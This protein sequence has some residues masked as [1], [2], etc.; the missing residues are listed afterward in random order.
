MWSRGSAAALGAGRGRRSRGEVVAAVGAGVGGTAAVKE[1]EDQRKRKSDG[2]RDPERNIYFGCAAA[3]CRPP[4]E[5]ALPLG[6]LATPT[7]LADPPQ[8]HLPGPR[9]RCRRYSP[10]CFDEDVERTSPSLHICSALG[11][12]PV[13]DNADPSAREPDGRE[14]DGDRRCSPLPPPAPASRPRHGGHRIG[15][16]Q[17]PPAPLR[18]LRPS[19]IR[20]HLC[21]LWLLLLLAPG[22]RRDAG[23]WRR[24]GRDAPGHGGRPAPLATSARAL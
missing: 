7:G 13:P 9:W 14:Q 12:I 17:R 4:L 23:G 6:R 8:V 3:R 24:P 11:R 20:A 18:P 19:L 5:Y 10:A 22:G 21:D 16:A 1:E 15:S 2:A